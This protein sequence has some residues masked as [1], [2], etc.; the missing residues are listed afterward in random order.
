MC[1]NI[2]D[3]LLSGSRGSVVSAQS[4]ILSSIPG[5]KSVFPYLLSARVS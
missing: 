4:L 1:S 2:R 3:W 5:W